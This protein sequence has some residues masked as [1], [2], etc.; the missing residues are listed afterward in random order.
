MVSTVPRNTIERTELDNLL[1]TNL[2]LK[3]VAKLLFQSNLEFTE[4]HRA[5][6]D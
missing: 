5:L 6:K 3:M 2:A 1:I 4:E